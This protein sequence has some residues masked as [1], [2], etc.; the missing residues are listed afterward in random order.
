QDKLAPGAL[1]R[2]HSA[3][4]PWDAARMLAEQGLLGIA[5]PEEDGGQ[6]GTLMHAVIAIQEIA[7]VCPKSADIVQ[8]GNFGPIRTF[9][10]YA[11][12]E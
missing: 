10:E 1:Q 4:Y 11:T 6:G 8:A 7:L 12:P 5:F 3:Q 2:A 9:V